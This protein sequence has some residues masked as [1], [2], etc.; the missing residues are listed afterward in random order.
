MRQNGA[1]L[2]KQGEPTAFCSLLW[3]QFSGFCCGD[4][5]YDCVFAGCGWK[6][7]C[8]SYALCSSLIDAQTLTHNQQSLTTLF[9]KD[10][11]ALQPPLTP[12][13]MICLPFS[14]S[15]AGYKFPFLCKW[16]EEW[17]LIICSDLPGSAEFSQS[18]ICCQNGLSFCLFSHH[19]TI[20]GREVR[21]S[22]T[23]VIC[24]I[25]VP[26]CISFP[27]KYLVAMH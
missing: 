10:N 20:K 23:V 4:I 27:S 12:R 8:T 22:L 15:G 24:K 7:S 17:C 18:L 5:W 19:F 1:V 26:E 13:A 14:R 9:L 21:L 3:D 6:M 16:F 2:A 25:L 11:L